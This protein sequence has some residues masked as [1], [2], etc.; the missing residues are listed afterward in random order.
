MPRNRIIYQSEAIYAGPSIKTGISTGVLNGFHIL[1]KIDN[2]VAANYGINVTRQDI[3][4]LGSQGIISRP[5]FQS[6]ILD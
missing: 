6:P 3:M 4:Q 5:I 1:K 2:V